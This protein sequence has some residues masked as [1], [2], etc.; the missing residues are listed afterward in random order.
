MA[1][2]KIRV[3][4]TAGGSL[5]IHLTQKDTWDALFE[6]QTLSP[7]SLFASGEWRDLAGPITLDEQGLFVIPTVKPR[8]VEDV[9]EEI[10][11]LVVKNLDDGTPLMLDTNEQ[12]RL[13]TRE[14]RAMQ[15]KAGQ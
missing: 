13:L 11:D 12:A 7:K 3:R 5:A 10:V 4:S 6:P 9:K 14:L 8:T 15:A 2:R 1:E